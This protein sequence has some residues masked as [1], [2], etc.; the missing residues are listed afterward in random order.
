MKDLI[1]EQRE[2]V[3]YID[4]H[5]TS[6]YV[7]SPYLWRKDWVRPYE[8]LY[9]A[10]RMF[11]RLNSFVTSSAFSVIYGK[12]VF[13]TNHDYLPPF[14]SAA[15]NGIINSKYNVCH[16]VAAF[17][18]AG[19]KDTIASFPQMNEEARQLL[20]AS[21]Y[22]FCPLCHAKG[23][24]SW[25]YQYRGLKVCPIHHVPFESLQRCRDD[26]Q[27]SVM[28]AHPLLY[29]IDT[30]PIEKACNNLSLN[31]KSIEL[32]TMNAHF[33][34][35][36]YGKMLGRTPLLNIGE[37]IYTRDSQN[38]LDVEKEMSSRFLNVIYKITTSLD[39]TYNELD[40]KQILE[41]TFCR[42]GIHRNNPR[43]SET[44]AGCLQI[45]I[46][47]ME[48]KLQYEQ[49]DSWNEILSEAF[50]KYMY[51][52]LGMDDYFSFRRFYHPY[53]KEAYNY[54]TLVYISSAFGDSRN[55]INDRDALLYAIDDHIRF[56]WERYRK[57]V[58]VEGMDK[59]NA[60]NV[61]PAVAYLSITDD[62]GIIHLQRLV[63]KSRF[64]ISEK[65]TIL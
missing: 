16:H 29:K 13:I 21:D 8:S 44:K 47:L 42:N 27:V 6:D 64:P 23:Y 41:K 28:D 26:K 33:D 18:S 17:F 20:V 25:F 60:I 40:A 56:Q 59:N 31:A 38:H 32:F 50:D 36:A 51:Y 10:L 55:C 61:L 35:R 3:K 45:Y 49:D 37:E 62:N 9:S 57:L 65:V 2:Y 48:L 12:K 54:H 15:C 24:H 11:E 53:A 46:T 34:I 5:R 63:W 30:E 14:L 58:I 52:V 4:N 43:F 22:R 19:N 39:D 1:T 7:L